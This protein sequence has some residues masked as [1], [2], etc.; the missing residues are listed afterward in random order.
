MEV[1]IRL[2]PLDSPTAPGEQPVLSGDV[3]L[4]ID[5]IRIETV[6]GE[7]MDYYGYERMTR[8]Q[9]V[10]GPEFISLARERSEVGRRQAWAD[11]AS[12]NYRDYTL[13]Q[14][15][16]DYLRSVHERLLRARPERLHVA[17]QQPEAQGEARRAQH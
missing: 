3:R 17:V 16:A 2:D 6:T 11:L 1:V 13:R 5:W 12:G 7:M 10:F 4:L 15:R 9:S 14:F 8:G